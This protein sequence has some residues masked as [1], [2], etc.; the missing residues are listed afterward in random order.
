MNRSLK[1]SEAYSIFG[2]PTT[3]RSD[4]ETIAAA[5]SEELSCYPKT[6]EDPTFEINILDELES[7][8]FEA[9]NPKQHDSDAN[10][11]EMEG[12]MSKM[13]WQWSEH[14]CRV[15]L[16][17]KEFGFPFRQLYRAAHR[18]NTTRSEMAGQILHEGVLIPHLLVSEQHALLHASA[19]A[20]P[21]S[22]DMICIGGT[23]G[24]G[25]TSLMLQ[26]C[27]EEGWCFAADDISVFTQNGEL[28]P[29]YSY[30]KIYG[31][32]LD[33]FPNLKA[34]V[35]DQKGLLDRLHWSTHHMRGADK[36]RRRI[37]PRKLF[38]VLPE[39][40]APKLSDYV[41]LSRDKVDKTSIESIS[42][43][44]AAAASAHVLA[45]EYNE[46]L[47]HLH[48]QR[49]NHHLNGRDTTEPSAGF[50]IDQWRQRIERT[51]ANTRCWVLRAPVGIDHR[52]FLKEA[53]PLIQNL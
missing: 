31:Y 30:P 7:A 33:A 24:S 48:W 52:L 47:N 49:F 51:L 12:R 15:D 13:H 2:I 20:R 40:Q 6:N 32:N 39:N 18:Q 19:I 1:E 14:A 45:T 41:I 16:S 22:K 4:D 50:T 21:G 46:F 11:F 43:E 44:K 29:N 37:D 23:G 53:W 26:A 25:K 38:S 17:I 8:T 10:G 34:K 3:V 36:V 35:F 42:V 28:H 27:L 9:R 5:L